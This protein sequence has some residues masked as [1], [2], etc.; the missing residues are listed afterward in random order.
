[1]VKAIFTPAFAAMAWSRLA[2]RSTTGM[3]SS[4]AR[5]RHGSRIVE[6]I[7]AVIITAG[8]RSSIV[9]QVLS[10]GSAAWSDS[11]ACMIVLHAGFLR[12]VA[13]AFLHRTPERI[14]QRLEQHAIDRRVGGLCCGAQAERD[15]GCGQ[16]GC[17]VA[18]LHAIILP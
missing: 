8:L 7:A 12:A 6:L 16:R 11:T 2:S 9:L 5:F 17:D 4:L 1:M 3:P 10:C 18:S 15:H 13:Y 14:G